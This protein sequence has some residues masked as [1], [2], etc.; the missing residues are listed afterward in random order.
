MGNLLGAREEGGSTDMNTVSCVAPELSGGAERGGLLWGAS[1]TGRDVGSSSAELAAFALSGAALPIRLM[2]RTL[3]NR[4]VE[5][6]S[7]WPRIAPSSRTAWPLASERLA[8]G[9]SDERYDRNVT[10][11]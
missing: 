9:V 8:S 10:Q 11:R 3:L 4:T 1:G 5:P 2:T 7:A 6:P